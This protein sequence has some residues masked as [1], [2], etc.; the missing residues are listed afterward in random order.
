V[1]AQ[2]AR[3]RGT[4]GQFKYRLGIQLPVV[5]SILQRLVRFHHKKLEKLRDLT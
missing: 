1:P 2:V 3:T 5:S 4:A